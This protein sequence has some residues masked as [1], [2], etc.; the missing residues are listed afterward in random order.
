MLKL[1][2]T[3]C[4]VVG[5]CAVTHGT[6]CAL[7]KDENKQPPA[8]PGTTPVSTTTTVTTNPPS[9][10][11]KYGSHLEPI[12]Q[13]I[14]ATPQQ[15]KQIT[16]IMQDFRPHIEP[17]QI[18]YREKQRQFLATMTS[19]RPAEEVMVKQTELN[20]LY[21]QISTEYCVMHLKIRKLLSEDQC[22]KY[23]NYRRNQGWVK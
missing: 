8:P 14:S 12:L 7:G 6:N 10:G 22:V 4:V 13:T 15:R 18:K 17:L 5:V 23:E 21:S 3:L 11:G 16:E 1:Q 20:E 2:T 9:L 19:A